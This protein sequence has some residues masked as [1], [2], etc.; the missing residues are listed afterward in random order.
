MTLLVDGFGQVVGIDA[1]AAAGWPS[2]ERPSI[3]AV[4]V[5]VSHLRRR[6]RSLGLTLATVRRSGHV[7]Q[8]EEM[9]APRDFEV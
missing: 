9:S 4:R 2:G 1:L 8:A 6:V 7:L 3:G 5:R